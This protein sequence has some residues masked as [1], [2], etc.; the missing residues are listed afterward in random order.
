MGCSVAAL[1]SAISDALDGHIFGRS[2]VSPDMIVNYVAG[3]EQSYL[4]LQTNNF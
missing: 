4:P 2:P 1:Q 3:R